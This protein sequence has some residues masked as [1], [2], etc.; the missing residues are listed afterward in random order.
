MTSADDLTTSRGLRVAAEALNW[1]FSRSEGAGGQSVNKTAT[2]AS[3]TID[4]SDVVC[5]LAQR[6]RIVAALGNTITVTSQVTRSQWRNRQLCLEQLAEMLDK[7][8][9]PPAPPR[10]KTK[11]SRGA[12][13]RRLESKRRDS[14]KK[15]DR[16]SLE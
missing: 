3:L 6:A 13:E 2:K 12:I 10:R 16:R 1:S 5:T 8:A 9:A 4:V 7:A 15:R 14:A 11:P